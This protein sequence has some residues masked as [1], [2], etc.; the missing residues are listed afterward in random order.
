MIL[1]KD[2]ILQDRQKQDTI[3]EG[4]NQAY[5]IEI[6][7]R[8]LQKIGARMDDNQ[9]LK[10]EILARLEHQNQEAA[11]NMFN[12]K[13]Q[14]DKVLLE[15]KLNARESQLKAWALSL[16]EGQTEHWTKIIDAKVK[17]QELRTKQDVGEIEQTLAKK[18]APVKEISS[19]ALENSSTNLKEEVL[20]LF[21]D[22]RRLR[23]IRF[24]EVY[25]LIEQNKAM[26]DELIGQQFQSQK[27]LMKAIVNKEVAER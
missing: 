13:S 18:A 14:E 2:H 6:E 15:T 22:D 27:A 17:E 9:H 8:I 24:Q 11:K 7:S 16:V 10:E 12:D 5:T 25:N 1:L 19:A 23:N 21:E 3:Q 4:K 20:Q 26:Q